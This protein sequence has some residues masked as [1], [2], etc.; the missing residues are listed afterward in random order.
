MLVSVP[1]MTA[2]VIDDRLYRALIEVV[3]S[4]QVL[5]DPDFI[6]PYTIDAIGRGPRNA[7]AVV[8]PASLEEVR[9][10]LLACRQFGQPVVPQGGNTGLV[11]G[12][13]PHDGEV[14]LS[15]RRLNEM[16]A[17]N[18]ETREVTVGAGVTIGALQE[19]ARQAGLAYA[20]DLS[21]RDSATVGG[22]IA[23]NAGGRN[24][25]AHGDTRRQVLGLQVVFADGTVG[26]KLVGVG[27]QSLGPDLMQLLVGSEGT[28]GV[29]TAAR[30]R[31]VE[32]PSGDRVVCLVAVETLSE[33]LALRGPGVTALEFFDRPAL[34]AVMTQRGFGRPLPG[35]PPFYVLVET[36]QTPALASDAVAVVDRRLWDYR[37]AIPDTI[38]RQGVPCKL[39][40][41]L[42]LESLDD[43]VTALDRLDLDGQRYLFGH[44]AEGNFHVN[45]IGA[46]DPR[47]TADQVLEVVVGLGGAIAS[48]H[49][50]GVDKAEWW[51]RT[52]DPS[53]VSKSRRIKEVLD[54]DNLL[55]PKV[56]WSG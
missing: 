51:R 42:P 36:A 7:A 16:S 26:T 52:T 23:T 5:V 2:N 40:V 4:E 30:L 28:L 12:S 11:G 29:I 46:S 37:E 43:F 56:F 55:N 6:T 1:K 25:V 3:G 17:V 39:D 15:V 44:L 33:G 35:D 13:V 49:G 48:E 22:T 54:P 50:I 27:K 31:L 24:V 21:S 20:V 32:A 8:R 41:G 45:I 14:V 10:V 19:H 38:N 9:L 47:R 53:L 34:E 18:A